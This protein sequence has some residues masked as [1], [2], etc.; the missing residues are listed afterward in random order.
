MSF[1][2]DVINS[3]FNKVI[4]AIQ[5]GQNLDFIDEYGYTPLIQ[6]AIHNNPEMAS[7]LLKHGAKTD[8]IDISGQN[9]LHWAIDNDNLDL[10]SLLI[11]Y[12]AD[13]N[14]Y[15]QDGQPPL[16]KP[17]LRKNKSLQ[18]V[19]IKAGADLNFAKDYINA[20]LMGH[21]F[22]LKGNTDVYTTNGLFIDI[23]MEGFYL[24]F[25]I[26]LIHDS[27]EKFINSYTANRLKLPLDDLKIIIKSLDNAAQLRVF[28]HYNQKIE[29]HLSKIQKL[30][31]MD[32]LLLPVSYGGH[33]ITF[34]KQ[35]DAWAKCDRG[36]QKSTDPIVIYKMS[37]S[38]SLTFKFYKELL[39]TRQTEK[40]I[41]QDLHVD[42]GLE[43]FA[44]LP[45]HHQITGNCSWA[46]VEASVPTMLFILLYRKIKDIKN[47]PILVKNIAKIHEAW[48]EWDKD[49]ALEESLLSFQEAS[50]NRKKAKATLLGSVLFQACNY[51]KPRDIVR[52]KKILAILMQK[53]F[54]YILQ[55]YVNVFIKGA[56][57]QVA[58]NFHEVL[59]AC[60][61]K[62]TDLDV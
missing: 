6:A 36:V 2:D 47:L 25:S 18:N 57:G 31:E 28:K 13:T 32:L 24:E 43:A 53:E 35:Q 37:K 15:T 44:K 40:T 54:Q 17:I 58:K 46:N 10:V 55:A 52:A 39:Y 30:L 19:L 60:G 50:Y 27:L 51:Q 9:A 49:R 14:A 34:I 29:D 1:S 62:L 45:I 12:K 59:K 56:K 61:L 16:F 41:K 42:L 33:A 8:P 23:D 4:L 5:N 22:E 48:L 11:K 38:D 3:K 7:L 26:G 21:R 20:K